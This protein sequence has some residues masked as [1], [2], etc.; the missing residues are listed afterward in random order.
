VPDAQGFQP[1]QL[2]GFIRATLT[3]PYWLGGIALSTVGLGLHAFALNGG[4]L[5]VVQLLMVLGVLFALVRAAAAAPGADPPQ[6]A[7]VGADAGRR[8][9]RFPPGGHSRRAR[10]NVDRGPAIAAGLLTVGAAAVCVLVARDHPGAT[11]AALLGIALSAVAQERPSLLVIDQLDAVSKA[12]GRMPLTF[13]VVADLVREAS[14]FPNM[15]VLLACR[16]FDVDNDDRIRTL[17]QSH[18]ANHSEVRGLSEDQVLTAVEAMGLSS[19]RLTQQQKELLRLPLHLKL[20]ASIADQAEVFS[21]AT[22]KD[23]F[24]AYW[25]RKRRD[26]RERRGSPVRFAEV[27]SVVADEMS[28][29]QRL[30]VPMSVLDDR[31]LLDDADVLASEQVLIR[32]GQQIAFF[33]ETFFDYAFARRWTRRGQTLVQF[34]LAGEQELFRRAQV[35][36]ILT[37]LREESPERFV[38]EMEA[39]LT[40]PRVR[41]HVKEVALALLGALQAPTTAEWQMVERLIGYDLPFRGPAV[42]GA[43]DVAVVRPTRRGGCD[44]GVAQWR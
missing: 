9:G 37:Y 35:R 25:D 27:V 5:A 30:T 41:F 29:R 17:I 36:Q 3:H 40:E 24:D 33:H 1:R 4:A 15:R 21:F 19:D 23:L 14:A 42:V 38:S 34:L 8:S 12:S 22:T 11:A 16:K 32:E 31:D 20:L 39:L 44:R 26:C 7:V 28:E 2:L 6:R 18:Q 10:D 43:A 13:D